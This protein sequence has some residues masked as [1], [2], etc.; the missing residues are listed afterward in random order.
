MRDNPFAR[1]FRGS[2][3]TAHYVFAAVFLVRLVALA[4]LAGSPSFLPSGGDTHF[5]DEWAKRIVAG[6]WTDGQAF[7]GLPL[8]AFSLAGLY[9]L[10][11][12]SPFIP[13]LLQA[14]ADAGTA[15]ILFKLGERVFGSA[16]KRGYVIGLGAA[17]T[18]AIFLPAQA[19]SIILMPTSWLVFV[20]WFLVWRVV[21][22]EHAPSPAASFIYGLL[23]GVTAMAVATILFLLPLMLAVLLVRPA[24]SLRSR[25]SAAALLLAGVLVGTAPCW[26]HNTFVAQDRVFLS[27]HSGVNFWIGNNPDAT[28]YPHFPEGLRAGQAAMLKDSV[29][30]AEQAAGK[31]LKR[32]EV[33]AF[34]SGKAKSYINHDPADW[35]KLMGTKLA[36]LWNAFQYDDLNVIARL[37]GE[38]ILL[39]GVAFGLIAALAIP[40]ILLSASAYPH[41]RWILAATLLQMAAVLPV[42]VTE[43]YRM[44]AVPGLVIFASAGLWEFGQTIMRARLR[45]A[46]IYLAVLGCSAVFVTLP[47]TDLLLWALEPYDSGRMAHE[48]GDIETAKIKLEAAYS[49]APKSAEIN[50]ALGNLRLA[51][52]DRPG[53]DQFYRRTLE[54]DPRHK[55]A[56][57]NLGVLALQAGDAPAAITY[58]SIAAQLEPGDAKAH[59][60]LAKARSGIGEHAAALAEI[61]RA[62]A[63]NGSEP[64]FLALRD[65]IRNAAAVQNE[66]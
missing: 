18:W 9:K 10:V 44:A 37:R 25:T 64:E 31:S 2:P 8:Y 47:R 55:G 62:I 1:L 6:Q 3:G 56:I 29:A 28:G 26:L 14:A 13:G 59:F 22:A 66:E 16:D 30:I 23:V 63:I 11:G 57:S 33:S 48:R 17:A 27:A 5:Y 60:L 21:A 53:A 24:R 43:R 20:A 52:G 65:E 46:A 45:R 58:F 49:Y 34:W 42:F 50:F 61:D 38:G 15:T 32:S 7:Y 36:N 51:A 39:P 12:Y 54:L 40:G 4:Q 19:Y 41:S 35:L